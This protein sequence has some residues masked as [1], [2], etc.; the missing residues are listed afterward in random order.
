MVKVVH[1]NDQLIKPWFKKCLKNACIKKN[2]VYAKF[3]RNPT[4][5]N[6]KYKACKNK[7]S[8]IIRSCEIMYYSKLI[9]NIKSSDKYMEIFKK[10]N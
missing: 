2:K 10:F 5:E 7:L 4:S 8:C 6:N 1:K 3:L 9:E